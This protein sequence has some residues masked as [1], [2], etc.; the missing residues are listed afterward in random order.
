M[1]AAQVPR[2]V[3]RQTCR[4]PLSVHVA[5]VTSLLL[6]SGVRLGPRPCAGAEVTDIHGNT[7]YDNGTVSWVAVPSSGRPYQTDNS[8]TGDSLDVFFGLAR[9][10]LN[11][12]LP[13]PVPFNLITE[14]MNGQFDISTQYMQLVN[15][16]VGLCVCLVLGILFLLFMPIVGCCLCCCRCCCGKCGGSSVAIYRADDDCKRMGLAQAMLLIG[17]CMSASVICVYVTN[18]KLTS[19]ISF[20]DTSVTSNLQDLD[21]FLINTV[22]EF[23]YIAV[24]MYDLIN[25]AISRDIDDIGDTLG[26]YLIPPLLHIVDPTISAIGNMDTTI[27]AVQ[28]A[29]GVVDAKVLLLHASSN[30]LN[31][32][33]TELQLNIS[34]TKSTCATY[35]DAT[36]Q[37]ACSAF[38]EAALAM[39]I[40]FS[41]FPGLNDT[42]TSMN[43]VSSQNLTV[44]AQEGRQTILEIASVIQNDTAS[45]RQTVKDTLDDFAAQIQGMVD[46]LTSQLTGMVDFSSYGVTVTGYIDMAKEYEDIRFYA[47]IGL[48]VVLSIS[49]VC[50]L[51]G[52]LLGCV[53]TKPGRLP[54]ERGKAAHCGAC[55]LVAGVSIAFILSSLLMLLTTV[56]FLPGALF[57]KTCQPITDLTLFSEFVDVGGIP[58]FSLAQLLLGNAS[59][60]L[61]IGSVLMECKADAA[62]FRILHLDTLVP[63]EEYMD[64]EAQLGDINSKFDDIATSFDLSSVNILTNDTKRT[65]DDFKDSGAS[66]I[67]FTKF[68]EVLSKDVL[69]FDIDVMLA[70]ISTIMSHCS[71]PN[72]DEWAFH[73]AV[74]GNIKDIMIPDIQA[75]MASL[76]SS[77]A[78]LQQAV[79]GIEASVDNTISAANATQAQ[80]QNEAPNIILNGTRDFMDHILNYIKQYTD[81]TLDLVYNDLAKCRPLW[82]LYES[83]TTTLCRYIVD[84]LNGFWFGIGWC[85]LFFIPAIVCALKL[86]RHYR[87]MK[88]CEGYEAD[89]DSKL[90]IDEM[91]V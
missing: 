23:N 21:S 86:S 88:R 83:L 57:H 80:I 70:N 44:M 10:F 28:S 51:C 31:A 18:T 89:G 82:N 41:E 39:E 4:W 15:F 14:A 27:Q 77:L 2:I 50:Y 8:Y 55:C 33:L 73:A 72:S 49:I 47:G 76:N 20:I 24:D 84:A 29:L 58:D 75:Q 52:I 6:F 5:V 35:C 37:A 61:T 48:M 32:T 81:R 45:E 30:I 1:N 19:T 13:A 71:S 54:T 53:G 40:D 59:I 38:S 22:S 85:L 62:P 12:I 16:G 3:T 46:Q 17:I 91:T 78:V 25:R 63:L 34:L 7:A 69:A 90:P 65:L 67:N 60:P 36:G 42:M 79:S 43:D 56:V 9:D 26:G 66:N 11:T 74:L 68:Q 64:Y 87:R